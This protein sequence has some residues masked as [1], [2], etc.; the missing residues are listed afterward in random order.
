MGATP[1][2]IAAHS[3]A[4]NV[5]QI[6]KK[7]GANVNLLDSHGNCA[8]TDS[9]QTQDPSLIDELIPSIIP[10]GPGLWRIWRDIALYKTKMSKPLMKFIKE[11][12]NLG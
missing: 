4:T 3:R 9:L 10:T 2:M 1:L 11:A 7:H 12:V 5:V 6:L 8:M